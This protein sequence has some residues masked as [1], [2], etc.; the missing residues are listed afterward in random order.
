M[1]KLAVV[2]SIAGILFAYAPSLRTM[3]Q[4]WVT[5]EDLAH[6]VLVPPVILWILYRERNRLRALPVEPNR[7][8]W[9]LL[10][11][12]A[13]LQMAS[14]R[15][16]GI[17]LGSVAFV[18]SMEVEVATKESRNLNLK[19]IGAHQARRIRPTSTYGPS[20]KSARFFV[21]RNRTS[22][23]GRAASSPSARTT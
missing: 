4:L 18:V 3:A 13:A 8:G 21:L 15:G 11:A 22:A 9:L 10:L 5:D 2:A 17:F 20:R 7:W 12:G 6:G 16:G 14:V 1:R 23:A 19:V